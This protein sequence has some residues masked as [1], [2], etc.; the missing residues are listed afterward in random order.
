M[1]QFR[2]FQGICRLACIGLLLV[3]S[4]CSRSDPEQAVRAQVDALQQAIDARDAGAV[5]DLLAEDFIGNEGMD[6]RGAKQLAAGVFLRHREI[7]ARLGPVTV[8]LRG[9][10]E[11]IARF[12]VLATGGSGGLLP[13]QGEAYQVQTGWRLQD[14]D[15][16]LLNASWT[17]PG[18]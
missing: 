2:G 9:E 4:A 18:V 6:R 10:R 5:E 16:K 3:V 17:P 13:E 8:D 11:A 12:S 15:W 7:G 14:G 1:Q